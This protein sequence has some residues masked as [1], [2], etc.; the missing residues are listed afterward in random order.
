MAKPK[1]PAP[2]APV[3]EWADFAA[4]HGVVVSDRV[5]ADDIIKTLNEEG[6][7]GVPPVGSGAGR[8][9][10]PGGRNHPTPKA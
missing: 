10:L 1:M 2:D 9:W 7:E 8:T 5:S 6:V 3:E 4:R